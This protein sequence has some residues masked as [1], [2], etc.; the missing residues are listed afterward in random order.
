MSGFIIIRW[1]ESINLCPTCK[2]NFRIR[3]DDILL[4]TKD[5]VV[6]SAILETLHPMAFA[7]GNIAILWIN[8]ERYDLHVLFNARKSN[9][10]TYPLMIEGQES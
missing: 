1:T 10:K 9:K 3:E 7:R 8:R 4:T 5:V 2:E 6:K